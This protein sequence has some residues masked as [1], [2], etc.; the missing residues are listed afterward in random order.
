MKPGSKAKLRQPTIEGRVVDTEYDKEHNCL[1][2]CL[3]WQD[4]EGETQQRWFLET[5]LE[6]TDK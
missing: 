1:R 4:A 5:E 3:E 2:H 6:E